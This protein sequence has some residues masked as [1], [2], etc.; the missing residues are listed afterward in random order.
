[1][2]THRRFCTLNVLDEESPCYFGYHFYLDYTVTWVT[3]QVYLLHKH[4]NTHTRVR[5]FVCCAKQ[6]VFFMFLFRY[7]I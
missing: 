3:T 6:R 5:V 4:T 1:M 2:Q 7:I